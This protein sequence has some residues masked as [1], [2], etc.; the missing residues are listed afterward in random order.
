LVDRRDLFVVELVPLG[1]V[2]AEG[3]EARSI[4]RVGE[5]I[6]FLDLGLPAP[7]TSRE[8]AHSSG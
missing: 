6:R 2:G 3:R 8:Q 7:S 1:D 4:L 5:E